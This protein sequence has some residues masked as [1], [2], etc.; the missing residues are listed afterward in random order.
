MA[1]NWGIAAA[2]YLIVGHLI[3]GLIARAAV[4]GRRWGRPVAQRR[5]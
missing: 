2:V 4:R 1:V 3:A 5:I